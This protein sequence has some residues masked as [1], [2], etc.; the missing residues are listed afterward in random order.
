MLVSSLIICVPLRI[1]HLF[2]FHTFNIT[3]SSFLNKS[4]FPS[5]CAVVWLQ[6]GRAIF[7]RHQNS[8]RMP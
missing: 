2:L 6:R 8:E 1:F 3:Y 4:I 7:R 5:V